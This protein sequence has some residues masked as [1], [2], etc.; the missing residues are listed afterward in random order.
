MKRLISISVLVTILFAAGSVWAYCP[1]VIGTWGT[2]YGTLLEGRVSEAWCG[3]DGSPVAPGQPGNVENAYSWDGVTLGTQWRVWGMAVDAS[4]PQLS[5][6]TVDAN[7]NGSRTYVTN[8][9]GGEY[10][11]SGAYDWTN[12][13]ED[14]TGVLE[15]YLVVTTLTFI[16]GNVVGQTSNVTLTGRFTECPEANNC[17]LEFA[18]AN[19]ILDWRSD[20][21]MPMPAGY[22]AFLCG[23]TQ[24]E[25]FSSCCITMRVNCAVGAEG[26]T[27]GALK[28]L[29]R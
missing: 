16:G 18:I 24:G 13:S 7:G 6:D 10:W 3:A 12:G 29:Y 1:D 28:Q 5:S 9:V 26:T 11:L 25:L 14:L 27:W 22:P 23:A 21:G 8:Y 4:G 15:S 2:Q 17:V 19:A 20:F